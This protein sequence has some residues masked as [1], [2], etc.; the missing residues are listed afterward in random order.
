LEFDRGNNFKCFG[1]LFDIGDRFDLSLDL[2]CV[3]HGFI[4]NT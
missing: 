1:D 4:G 3:Y 2:F